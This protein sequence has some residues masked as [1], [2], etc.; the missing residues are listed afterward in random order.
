MSKT[1]RFLPGEPPFPGCPMP[2]WGRAWDSSKKNTVEGWI[3]YAD[4]KS[5]FPFVCPHHG[6]E[7][8]IWFAHAE[9]IYEEDMGQKW[10]PREREPYWEWLTTVTD[11][12]YPVLLLGEAVGNS[13]TCAPAIITDG[14]VELVPTVGECKRRLAELKRRQP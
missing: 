2:W 10:K 7:T 3:T 1:L 6:K 11:D 8:A 9:P 13:V 5:A 4:P 12:V 14:I